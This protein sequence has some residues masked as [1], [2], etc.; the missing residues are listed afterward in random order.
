MIWH[1]MDTWHGLIGQLEGAHGHFILMMTH[2]L[3]HTCGEPS[4]RI[5]H[6][7]VWHYHMCGLL[8]G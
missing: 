3:S 4:S 1:F 7:L 6:C 5:A 2:L 8:D